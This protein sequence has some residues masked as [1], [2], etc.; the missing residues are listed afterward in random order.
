MAKKQKPQ[1]EAEPKPVV[2]DLKFPDGIKPSRLYL[3]LRSAARDAAI[4]NGC[5]EEFVSNVVTMIESLEFQAIMFFFRIIQDKSKGISTLKAQ[6]V[7]GEIINAH[8]KAHEDAKLRDDW[9]EIEKENTEMALAIVEHNK[10]VQAQMIQSAM[11]SLAEELPVES[12][13][14]KDA[15]LFGAPVQKDELN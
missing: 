15:G 9:K 2:D 13:S 4:K 3:M 5:P 7:I 8:V 10:K 6:K 11:Q 1:A 14:P 12:V